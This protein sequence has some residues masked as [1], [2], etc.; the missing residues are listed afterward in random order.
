MARAYQYTSLILLLF[1]VYVVYA[2]LQLRYFTH[3]GPGSGFFGVWL[4]G[5]L[6]IFSSMFFLQ[7]TMSRWRPRASLE[8][9]PPAHA[10]LNVL[11]TLLMLCAIV[12]FL[13]LLGYQVSMLV[14]VFVILTVVGR[15]SMWV[16]I[17]MSVAASFGVYHVFTKILGV[18]LP[19]GELTRM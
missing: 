5:L 19:V 11:V 16:A 15:Q 14:F 8:L 10:R 17:V 9:L 12:V 3:L 18:M 7:N 13:P 4:G 1:G 6:V 2:S